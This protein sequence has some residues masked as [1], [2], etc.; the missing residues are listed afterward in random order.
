MISDPQREFLIKRA[1]QF[2]CFLVQRLPRNSAWELEGSHAYRRSPY[3]LC[4]KPEPG[5]ETSGLM[6]EIVALPKHL[7]VSEALDTL[8][9]PEI[10]EFLE[11]RT[12]GMTLLAEDQL[13]SKVR[14][15]A[16]YNPPFHYITQAIGEFPVA[17]ERPD[18]SA[19]EW[20]A[21]DRRIKFPKR[22][23]TA[24]FRPVQEET[25]AIDRFDALEFVELQQLRPHLKQGEKLPTYTSIPEEAATVKAMPTRLVEEVHRL[26]GSMVHA[27][28]W[29]RQKRPA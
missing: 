11:A 2:D 19:E 7:S 9:T 16:L 24:Q 20:R 8:T 25:D 21:L 4:Y 27:Q 10:R 26:Y 29:P 3:A 18:E 14:A 15:H 12:E 23:G 17:W 13:F 28:S 6:N 5:E 22:S 1:L